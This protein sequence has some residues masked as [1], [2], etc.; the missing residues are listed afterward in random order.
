MH[1]SPIISRLPGQTEECIFGGVI[2]IT[3]CYKHAD[4]L[5]YTISNAEIFHKWFIITSIK[6]QETIDF[7]N[8]INYKN[9]FELIFFPFEESI[10]RG[11]AINLALKEVYSRY[12]DRWILSIDADV[13]LPD[14][15]KNSFKDGII[16]NR[17]KLYF[18][19]RIIVDSFES[20]LENQDNLTVFKKCR[21]RPIGFF[22][23]FF[24]KNIYFTERFESWG[25]SDYMF[26]KHFGHKPHAKKGEDTVQ[27]SLA[28]IHIGRL[29]R[30]LEER[31]Y[32]GLEL[33]GAIP[34]W[35]SDLDKQSKTD[36][37]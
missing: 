33:P 12:P 35:I 34:K 4:V 31:V 3:V 27:L 8:S 37:K 22:Q 36:H 10:N 30:H 18:T 15:F 20:Y 11:K 24:K 29:N 21:P 25:H 17:N 28:V 2:A 9:K 32:N 23:F 16:L 6:D 1:S 7:I 5:R 19:S 14:E 26:P 13:Y